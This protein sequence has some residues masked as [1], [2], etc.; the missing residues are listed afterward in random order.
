MAVEQRAHA[1]ND[2][3]TP[4]PHNEVQHTAKSVARYTHRNFSPAGFS[5]WQAAQGAKGGRAKGQ[6]LRDQLLP[7][8]AELLEA[9][10]SQAD[11]AREVEQSRQT[12]SNWV[13]ALKSGSVKKLSK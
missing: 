13:R 6:A 12:I 3:P 4:L 7:V 5:A 10:F 9:G 2:F 8:V 11:I 1:Y